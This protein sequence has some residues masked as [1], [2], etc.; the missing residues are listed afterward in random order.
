MFKVNAETAKFIMQCLGECLFDVML[1]IVATTALSFGIY[2]LW[3]WD[4]PLSLLAAGLSFVVFAV[5]MYCCVTRP[6]ILTS[7]D[8]SCE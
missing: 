5:A 2:N 3:S 1:F 4:F 8:N 6:T 7:G